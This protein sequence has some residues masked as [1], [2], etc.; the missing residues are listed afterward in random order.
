MMKALFTALVLLSAPVLAQSKPT[1][2]SAAPADDFFRQLF[3]TR[4]FNSGRPS[5]I[6][7]SPDEKTVFFLR[8]STTSQ[9]LSLYA[10]DVATQETRELLTPAALL[11]GAEEKLSPEEQ[12]RRER[13]RVS[14]RGF[15]SF[16][17]SEDGSKL[18][19][20]L[21]GKL[22]VVA[23]ESGK[24]TA[25]KTGPGVIDP[26]FTPGG[27][28]V[29]YVRD[30]D[31]YRLDLATNTERRVTQGGTPEKT[32]GLAEFIAQEEM[33]R[34]TGYWWSP[35]AKTL[36]YTE[37]DTSGVEKLAIANT[38][39]PEASAQ[40]LSYPRAGTANAKVRLGLISAAG[41]K[42]TW[43][44][45]D[46]RKY[47][48]LATVKWPAKGPLTV[49]VQ[50]RTQTEE[51]LLAVDTK[52][53]RTTPLLVETDEAWLN[54]D[55]TFP[56]WLSDGSGFLW[57]TERNGASELELRDAT[58]QRVRT[59]VP[60]GAGFSSLVAYVE[61]DETVY[62]NG[63][64]TA[65]ESYLWRVRKGESPTRVTT[66]GP[67]L[68][69]G[70]VSRNG[71]V[72]VITSEGPTS[73]KSTSVLKADGT[74]LGELPSLAQEP[75][76]QPRLEVRMV[77]SGKDRYATSL[78]RP[79]D[80]KPGVKLPVIVDVYAGPETQMV[81]QSMAAHL[82][83]QWMADQGFIVV[84]LDARGVSP[85][86]DRALRKP[87][88]DFARVLLDEQVSALRE[89]AKVVP[90]MDLNRVGIT[91]SSHGGYM[92]ALAVLTRPEVFKAAVAVSAVTD[93]RDYDTHLTERFLG[94]PDE[95]PQAYEQSSLLTH[96]KAGQPMGKLLV[97][98]GTADDNVFFFHALKLSNALFRAGQPHE[99]LP[100][101]GASHMVMA[102]PFVAERLSQE[103]LRYFKQHL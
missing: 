71:A 9:A 83:S 74:R 21:S 101:N 68:E 72:L 82:I 15:S 65:A 10:F 77:G 13:M 81:W 55:Q 58:G 73:M 12:A 42:T 22:Y 3:A 94:L 47:P 34:F 5:S 28:Q 80:A 25:L 87:K 96:V 2:T 57:H 46:A 43:V 98:H 86:A 44:S 53:G 14:S 64:T 8:N 18:L 24:V 70:R 84:R 29:G 102:D 85:L 6:T 66:S 100:L 51:V 49:L 19:V 91:G 26:R 38:L 30:Q 23:R 35:D 62:F 39:T 69:R 90:E 103:T 95:H 7:L 54:L 11:Q 50:N 79:R 52:T 67:A 56:H 99:F 76:I 89:L 45:W 20:G 75:P 59:L 60:P 40:Q 48:Y 78:V 31:V 97:I 93:W 17:L 92:S 41:G 61:R 32:H 16:A 33:G 37:S 27:G 36:A 63:G 4:F 88:Y 1:P